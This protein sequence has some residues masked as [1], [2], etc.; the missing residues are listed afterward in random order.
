MEFFGMGTWEIVFVFIIALLVFGPGKLP[1]VARQVGKT[2]ASL[3]RQSTQITNE[4]KKEL[5][6]VEAAEKAATAAILDSVKDKPEQPP[7]AIT[8]RSVPPAGPVNGTGAAA[9][10]PAPAREIETRTS[11]ED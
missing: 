1:E 11:G 2:M 9:H 7:A 3:K 5:E 6:A 4:I 10:S 8:Q